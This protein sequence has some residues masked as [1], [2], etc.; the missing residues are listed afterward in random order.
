VKKTGGRGQVKSVVDILGKRIAAGEYDQG[1]TLPVEQD[2]ADSLGVGRNALREA[3]KVL[4]GK[5]L[6]STAPR[7]GTKIR[8]KDEWNMLD[9][10][11]LS[12][13][14]DPETATSEFLLALLEIRRIIEPKAAELAASRATREDVAAI[15]A[16]YD[17]MQRHQDDP[18][19]R[20]IADIALHTA[21]L[22]ASH[23]A[24][25]SHFR[26]AISTYLMAH[27]KIGGNSDEQ[28][29][30]DDL[31]LHHDIAW[32]I[33]RGQVKAAYSTTVRMLAHGRM[34][35]EAAERG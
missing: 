27:A 33:A 13:H 2:L 19:Q 8:P 4:S 22:A 32:A 18:E 7:S 30:H 21:I 15:L 23:N 12:W 17:E 29:L 31:E 26:Y 25:I 24:F 28:K 16:A 10:D 34:R 11:V 6:I 14:A 5:G 20:V 1:E 35:V 3:V 9:Q